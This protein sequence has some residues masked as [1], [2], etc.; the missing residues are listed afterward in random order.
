MHIPDLD[1]LLSEQSLV[2]VSEFPTTIALVSM[3]IVDTHSYTHGQCN[4]PGNTHF[5]SM[6]NFSLTLSFTMSPSA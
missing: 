2:V 3:R 4:C 6:L 1:Q 5:D